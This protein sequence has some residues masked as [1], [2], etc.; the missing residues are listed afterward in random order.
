MNSLTIF[1]FASGAVFVLKS[2]EIAAIISFSLKPLLDSNQIISLLLYLLCDLLEFVL[3][4][5]GLACLDIDSRTFFVACDL[6]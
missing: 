3:L 1:L 6:V 2:A 4:D 5:H